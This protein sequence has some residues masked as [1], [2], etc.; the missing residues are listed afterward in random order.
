[1]GLK[2]FSLVLAGVAS[3]AGHAHAERIAVPVA[4]P[5]AVPNAARPPMPAASPAGWITPNDYPAEA[6]RNGV[7]GIVGFVLRIDE[8]GAVMECR[9]SQSSGSAVLD[10]ATCD[11]VRQRALFSPAR[12]SDGQPV[13]GSYANTVR[14]QIPRMNVPPQDSLIS[15]TFVIETN[16]HVRDCRLTELKSAELKR[17]K[18]EAA[19]SFRER[20]ERTFCMAQAQYQPYL[21]ENGAPVSK[22][23]VVTQSVQT[24]TLGD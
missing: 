15:G 9:I 22:R 6:I 3:S 19:T 24:Q 18:G 13:R 12:G 2:S 16:G 21:D 8:S 7:E 14:W 11:A 23:V 20:A 5:P 4:P 1:M 17:L 10:T